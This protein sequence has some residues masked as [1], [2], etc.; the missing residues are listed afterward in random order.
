M[1]KLTCFLSSLSS[2][3]FMV[4]LYEFRR[5]MECDCHLWCEVVHRLTVYCVYD[6]QVLRRL[7]TVLP[8]LRTVTDVTTCKLIPTIVES[9]EA[10]V[11]PVLMA[12][13]SA[14]L[15]SAGILAHRPTRTVTVTG[16]MAVKLIPATMSTTAVPAAPNAL[17]LPMLPPPASAANASTLASLGGVTAMVTGRMAARLT[18]MGPTAAT[19]AAAAPSA[20]GL[21]M[22][23]PSAAAASAASR[24]SPDF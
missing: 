5:V 10:S 20:A 3:D 22:L 4:I 15:A 14:V 11:V 18:S 12:A 13:P 6:C 7:G 16:A 17:P 1:E 21:R 9:V 2:V 19:A 8:G 23:H 24:A